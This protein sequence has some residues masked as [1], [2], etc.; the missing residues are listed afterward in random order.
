MKRFIALTVSMLLMLS[1]VAFAGETKVSGFADIWYVITDEPND[2]ATA[3]ADHPTEKKFLADAEID[4]R[5]KISD[6]LT[7]L[8]DVEFDLAANGGANAGNALF[9]SNSDSGRIEQAAFV[10][11]TLPVAV[12]GG[13]FNNPIGL[14]EEDAPDMDFFS[15]GQIY[16]ILDGQTILDGDNIA[17]AALQKTFGPATITV[18]YLDELNLTAEENSMAALLNLN[19]MKGLDLEV[20]YVT[21]ADQADSGLTA[22]TLAGDVYLGAESALDV[23]LTVTAVPNLYIGVEY[24]TAGEVIDS[25]YGVTA[26]YS[27]LDNLSVAARYDA[28]QYADLNLAAGGTLAAPDD[29]TSTT[30]AVTYGL[31]ENLDVVLEHRDTDDADG[32]AALAGLAKG[33]GVE[34]TLEFI[35]RF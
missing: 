30:V 4:V 13:V 22:T 17:G 28:V 2:P 18:A 12:I 6:K 19:I 1:G 11:T 35:A 24:F 31:D 20:G 25:A 16:N 8:L 9:G 26:K 15:H 3:G 23:N 7:V 5:S 14:E 10:S 34:T 32:I 21:A 33:D 29:T 27:I